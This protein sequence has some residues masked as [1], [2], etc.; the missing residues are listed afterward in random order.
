MDDKVTSPPKNKTCSA[1][2]YLRQTR[3]QEVHETMQM[4]KQDGVPEGSDLYFKALD[5]FKNS[6]CR[7]Q[8]KNMR[9]PANRVDWIEWTWTKG[10]QK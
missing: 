4:L 1:E 2:D 6:V 9:D 5:L 10:K 7:V 8:Y 3:E